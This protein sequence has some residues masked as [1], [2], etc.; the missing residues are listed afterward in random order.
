MWESLGRGLSIPVT[1][2][3]QEAS[4]KCSNLCRHST[5]Y[6]RSRPTPASRKCRKTIGHYYLPTDQGRL[7]RPYSGQR[8]TSIRLVETGYFTA[9]V[10]GSINAMYRR[11]IERLNPLYDDDGCVSLSMVK[12]HTTSQRCMLTAANLDCCEMWL[13]RSIA[14]TR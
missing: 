14:P 5:Q 12:H 6:S 3:R 8:T 2:L 7:K 1:I 10:Y 4:R 9:S 11:L 13:K